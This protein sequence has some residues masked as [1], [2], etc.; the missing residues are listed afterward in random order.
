MAEP[1]PSRARG[2]T[3]PPAPPGARGV[4]GCLRGRRPLSRGGSGFAVSG[5]A[6]SRPEGGLTA[7]RA[8]SGCESKPLLVGEGGRALLEEGAD[9]LA[10]VG[11]ERGEDLGPVLQ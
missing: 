4:Q 8:T 11:G 7:R 1:R 10:V 5:A 3:P 2:L 9:R 6:G